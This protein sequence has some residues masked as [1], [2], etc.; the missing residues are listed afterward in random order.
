MAELEEYK[1]TLN[2]MET[3]VQLTEED[4][5]RYK[6]V[7]ADSG[8]TAPES[9]PA[10]ND[11]VFPKTTEAKGSETGDRGL[12]DLTKA[13]TTKANKSKAAETK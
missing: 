9:S 4:A 5:K 2:G 12:A 1:V 13:D 3:T 6:A 11:P 8:E 7:R 10:A